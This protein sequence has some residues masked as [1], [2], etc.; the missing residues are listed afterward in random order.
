M[1]FETTCFNFRFGIRGFQLN[2]VGLYIAFTA[3]A[4]AT[5]RVTAVKNVFRT[6]AP[7]LAGKD[8]GN[9]VSH[10]CVEGS[11]IQRSTA[12]PEFKYR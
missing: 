6:V 3:I 10:L 5:S 2:H 7:A 9:R 1:Q 8:F 4:D 12:I 11:S